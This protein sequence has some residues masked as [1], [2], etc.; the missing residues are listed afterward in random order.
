MH[1]P[2]PLVAGEEAT[3]LVQLAAIADFT[4]PLSSR[5]AGPGA[6]FIHVDFV[7]TVGGVSSPDFTV[8]QLQ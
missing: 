7:N 6:G 1:V 3:P 8:T 4:N 5:G 2:V